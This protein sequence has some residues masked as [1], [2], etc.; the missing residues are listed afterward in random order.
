MTDCRLLRQPGLPRTGEVQVVV[1]PVEGRLA[2][3]AHFHLSAVVRASE[4]VP[5]HLREVRQRDFVGRRGV[6][7]QGSAFDCFGDDRVA[8][9]EEL[10]VRAGSAANT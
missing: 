4:L 6:E 3:D 1:H 2:V 7:L 8:E 5:A 10:E 9:C